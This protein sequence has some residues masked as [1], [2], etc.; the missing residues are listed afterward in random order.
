MPPL[1]LIARSSAAWLWDE[2]AD[3]LALN[4]I[5]HEV[6]CTDFLLKRLQREAGP[7]LIVET[8]TDEIN[9]GADWEWWFMTP[10]G[11]ALPMRVQAKVMFMQPGVRVNR[12]THPRYEKL[13]YHPT[14]AAYSQTETLIHR[15]IRED[16]F[17]LYCLYTHFNHTFIAKH[18]AS[19]PCPYSP[20]LPSAFGVTLVGAETVRVRH[21]RYLAD[22]FDEAHAFPCLFEQAY[23]LLW[24]ERRLRRMFRHTNTLMRT[25]HDRNGQPTQPDLVQSNRSLIRHAAE[26]PDYV[27]RLHQQA[28]VRLRQQLASRETDDTDSDQSPIDDERSGPGETLPEGTGR[29]TVF[30]NAAWITSDLPQTIARSPFH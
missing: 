26:V 13:H 24:L 19:S 10:A 12:A 20:G 5:L 23:G 22:L 11:D 3:A 9:L 30:L 25:G 16:M 6:A 28:L 4:L 7:Q 8:I 15:A 27:Q 17:P 29:V 1:D 21:G 2:L 18:A 14:G